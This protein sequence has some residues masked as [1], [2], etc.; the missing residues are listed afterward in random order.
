MYKQYI[1]IYIYIYMCGIYIYRLSRDLQRIKLRTYKAT[2]RIYSIWYLH[3]M[4]HINI[5]IKLSR[6]FINP[7]WLYKWFGPVLLFDSV[8]KS[9]H[10]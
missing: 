5:F 2:Y 8:G 9:N 3:R 4:K 6:E 10:N 7:N 1:Y